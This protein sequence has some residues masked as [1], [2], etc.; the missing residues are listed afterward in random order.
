MTTLVYALRQSRWGVAGFSTLAFIATLVQ[1]VGFYRSAGHSTAERAAFGRGVIALS[2]Q[3]AVVLPPPQRPDTAGGY[4]QYI[5]LGALAVAFPAWGLVAGVSAARWDECR[6]LTEAVLA[7]GVR[8]AALPAT[9]VAAFGLSMILAAVAAGLGA[10]LGAQAGGE[11]LPWQTA[12]EAAVNLAALGLCC[13]SLTFLCAQ[14]APARAAAAVAGVTLL[15]LFLTNSLSRALPALTVLRWLSPWRYYELSRPLAP[16][17]PFDLRAVLVLVGAAA[18]L[19]AAATVALARRDLGSPLWSIRPRSRP[20]SHDVST[21]AWWRAPVVRDLYEHRAALAAWAL[22]MGALA[23]VLV[24]MTRAAIEPL[25]S[26]P[27]I[28]RVLSGFVN[29][30]VFVSF[31]DSY[32]LGT[33]QLLLVAYVITQVAIWAADDSSGRLQAVL[34]QPRSRGGVIVER[35]AVLAAASA[36]IAAVTALVVGYA[37]HADGIELDRGRL[38]AASFL[39]VPFTLVFGA[40]GSLLAS[41]QPRAA[42]GLLGAFAFASFI[43]AATAPELGW[44]GWTQDLSAF[45]WFGSPLLLGVDRLGLTMMLLLALL[46]F[47]GSILV[48][49]R[50]DVGD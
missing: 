34:S 25:L 21:L 45:G 11:S 4:I 27:E 5:G 16:G 12:A 29:G 8:R 26:I 6:G 2:V 42:A 46:G 24:A 14:L 9:R 35:A 36:L 3:L 49:Q 33:A 22:G 30:E 50:R 40:A 17:G 37:A 38:A 48:F 10:G 32:W 13:Y 47:A 20:A 44:P 39:L 28:G 43:T 1:S 18:V 41:W 23:A 15:A 31:L 19:T 7:A